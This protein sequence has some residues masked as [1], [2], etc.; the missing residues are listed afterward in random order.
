MMAHPAAR[1]RGSSAPLAPSPRLLR[2]TPAP[3]L[4]PPPRPASAL[5]RTAAV[6]RPITMR[7]RRRKRRVE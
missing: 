6:A 7:F 3:P 5:P 1:R 2:A 4:S